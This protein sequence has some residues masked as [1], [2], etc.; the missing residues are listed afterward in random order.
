MIEVADI[1][2]TN[3]CNARCPQCQRTAEIGLDTLKGLPMITWSLQDFIDYFPKVVDR[4][5]SSHP[6][7]YDINK[8]DFSKGFVLPAMQAEN[9]DNKEA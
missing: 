3:L 6:A 7:L 4:F 2:L 1:N 5:K 8:E 9:I